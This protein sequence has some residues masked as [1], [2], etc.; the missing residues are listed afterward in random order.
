M[1]LSKKNERLGRGQT[2]NKRQRNIF[3]G[4]VVSLG[5]VAGIGTLAVQKWEW[6]I[7]PWSRRR[8]PTDESL[9]CEEAGH[10]SGTEDGPLRKIREK[11]M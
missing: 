11:D 9:R 10:S 4:Y 8:G 7:R 5:Y 3:G 2:K 1:K 6:T